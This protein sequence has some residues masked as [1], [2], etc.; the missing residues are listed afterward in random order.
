MPVMHL[1]LLLIKDIQHKKIHQQ[2]NTMQI[3]W[4]K[5]KYPELILS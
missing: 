4:T 5:M 3:K 2:G 1:Q